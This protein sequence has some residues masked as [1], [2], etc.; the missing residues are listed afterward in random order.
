ML[1]ESD[2]D[3]GSRLAIVPLVNGL[4]VRIAQGEKEPEVLGWFT[5]GFENMKAEPAVLYSRKFTTAGQMV[6]ALVP[7]AG[8]QAAPKATVAGD[9]YS[10]TFA[11][12][13]A[14]RFT[15]TD[16]SLQAEARGERFAATEPA[17]TPVAE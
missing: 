17:L 15:I 7:L 16:R 5:L 1:A 3:D 10:L 8:G 13:R 4:K 14:D 6:Y 12:G 2:A 9:T 11:D